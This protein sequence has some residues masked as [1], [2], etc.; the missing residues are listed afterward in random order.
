[1]TLIIKPDSENI[2]NLD[3]NSHDGGILYSNVGDS[4]NRLRAEVKSETD[5]S[6]VFKVI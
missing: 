6:F 4:Q 1:M 5:I 3:I 2:F